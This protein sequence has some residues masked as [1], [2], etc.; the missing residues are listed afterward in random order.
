M[1]CFTCGQDL[2]PDKLEEA[3]RKVAVAMM[4]LWNLDIIDPPIGSK[5]PRAI[6][7]LVAIEEIIKLNDWSWALP[8]KGNGP[9]QW[10]GMTAGAA[11]RGA[12]LDPSWL[13]DYFASTYRL[14][15]WATY[16]RFSTKSKPN[17]KPD[18]LED[19][20]RLYVDLR[21]PFGVEPRPGDI[22]IVG[23]GDPTVG[24]HVTVCISFANGV[25]DTISG[26]GGGRGP[27]DDQREG[28]S[29]RTYALSATA[30]YR[31]LWLIRPA[32][33]DLL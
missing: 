31:P 6:A 2:P 12:G 16:Q 14:S 15:M 19:D 26:N 3:G 5:H 17:P 18:A 20:R 21:K 30:G 8:Y 25:F 7:S 11:W 29:R 9:P 23:D 32:K 10:C 27:K 22:I 13:R 4:K 33:A 28:V 24:D 1:K